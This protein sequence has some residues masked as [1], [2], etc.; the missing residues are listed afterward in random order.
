VTSTE[1]ALTHTDLGDVIEYAIG[2]AAGFINVPPHL[3]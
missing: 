3:A 1:F 2:P